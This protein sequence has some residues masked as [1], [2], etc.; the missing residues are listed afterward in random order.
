[1]LARMAWRDVRSRPVETASLLALIAV[2]AL[3]ATVSAGLLQAVAGASDRLL[4][5]AVAPDVVQMHT[6]TVDDDAVTAWAATRPEVVASQIVPLLT[7]DGDRIAL[8]GAPQTGSAQQNSLMVPAAERDLL[9]TLDGAPLTRVERGTVWLPVYYA[10]EDGLETGRLV[11]ITGQGGFRTELTVA[12]FHRDAIMNTAIASSKRLAVSEADFAAIA[13]HTGTTEHLIEFWLKDP[14]QAPVFTAAYLA[15]GLPAAGPTVDRTTFELLTIF[16]EAINAGVVILA[17]VLLLVVGL[18]CLRLALLAAL[19]R[20]LRQLG[21]LKAIGIPSRSIRGMHLARYGGVAAAACALGLAGG[22]ALLPA[23]SATFTS[24]TGAGAEGAAWLAPVVTAAGMLALVGLF[25]FAVLRR[26]DRISAVRALRADGGLSHWRGPRLSLHRSRRLPVGVRLGFVGALRRWQT[27]GLLIAVFA[28]STFVVVVPLSAA[29]TLGSSSFLTYMGVPLSDLR[30]DLPADDPA[31]LPAAVA[32]L[33]AD[34]DV[35]VAVPHTAVRAEIDD[36]EGLPVSVFVENGDQTILP[37]TYPEGRAPAAEGEIALSLVAL[38]RIDRSVGDLI[39][40]RT[41][42]VTHRVTIVG[43]YQDVTNG[44]STGRA[45][46]PVAAK[47][48]VASTI[49]VG[50]TQSAVADRTAERLGAALPGARVVVVDAYRVQTLGPVI[51]RIGTTAGV[52]A[53]AA[54]AI[55]V[56]ITVLSTRMVLAADAGQIAIQRALGLP[57]AVVRAQYATASLTALVAAVPLG[58]LAAGTAGEGLFNLLFEA[59]YGGLELAGQGTSR[60]EFVTNPALTL[61][62]LPLVLAAAVAAATL[63]ASRDIAAVSIRK[64]VAE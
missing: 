56:L 27:Q 15:A 17:A 51:D 34:G 63:A 41:G 52:A 2:S 30:V 43:A 42:D 20:E 14:A 45:L 64:V 24:Y 1:M 25:M 54:L 36:A 7:L 18:L 3:L 62:A 61:L 26:I 11:T 31:A 40:V 53:A 33:E 48:A 4:N 38:S 46:L 10:I 35:A 50:L 6:G 39:E 19:S 9:L 22:L 5:Q 13:A 32:A 57:D 47:D 21:V 29:M 49:A 60:I 55:A 12:G 23:L 37:L 58:V 28:I 16:G 59:L 44:G 8:D